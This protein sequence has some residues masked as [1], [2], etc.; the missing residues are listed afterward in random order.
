MSV[1]IPM[2]RRLTGSAQLVKFY[3]ILLSKN[4]GPPQCSS[5]FVKIIMK[6]KV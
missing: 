6:R 4:Y 5:F 2:S 1:F 3:L